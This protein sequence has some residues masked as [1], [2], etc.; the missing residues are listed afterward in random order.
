MAYVE[1][2]DANARFLCSNEKKNIFLIGDSIRQGYCATVKEELS[3]DAQAFYVNDNC[4]NTQYVITN[5]KTW[6]NMFSNPNMVDI[7]HFN[8][9]HWDIAHWCGGELPLTSEQEYKRNI[10]I[11]IDMIKK[12]F[13]DAKIIFATTTPM[14]P[15]GAIGINPRN[16]AEIAHY[17]D[18]ACAVA[19]ENGV[20]INDL[21][22]K[23]K[24]WDSIAYADYCH[25][26]PESF[27]AL[28]KIV[29]EELRNY[30]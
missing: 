22:S 6:A 4:R 9:G 16:N 27:N 10:K 12:L 24:A 15:N 17:N 7:I 29:A 19:R 21:F 25:F 11:I 3:P 30:L 23:T 14:N 26:T 8:C 13:P 5:L 1:N 18:I 2:C 28:G 20:E